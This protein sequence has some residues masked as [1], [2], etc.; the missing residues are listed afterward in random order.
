MFA[1]ATSDTATTDTVLGIK[2]KYNTINNV[3]DI[4]FESDHTSGTFTYKEGT[5]TYTKNL[6]EGHLHYTTSRTT[7]NS[8]S[9]WIERTNPSKQRVIRTHT[10]GKT[11]K[12]LFPVDCYDKSA[13]LTDLEISVSV[14]GE[15][16]SLTTDYTLVNG[17]KN[18]YVKFVKDLDIDDQ[19]RLSVYSASDKVKDKGIYEVPDNLSTNSVNDKLGTFTYGKILRHVRDIFEKN[20]DLS[21]RLPGNTN[22]RDNPDSRLLGGTIHQHEGPLLPAIYGLIDQDSNVINAIEYTAHEYEKWYDAFLTQGKG[23]Y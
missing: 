1:F 11:E 7:H 5:T 12:K 13:S 22:L 15:K 8:R 14:N 20:S 4:V 3:G 6:A 19:V 17:T 21:G 23:N 16:K 2:V 9:A 18:K 10:V